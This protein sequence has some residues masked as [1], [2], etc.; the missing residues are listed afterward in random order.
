[1]RKSSVAVIL[2]AV[3]ISLVLFIGSGNS[4]RADGKSGESLF[5][6]HC[7]LCH[8]DGGNIVNPKKTLHKKDL[9]ANNIKSKDDI[10]H[11]MRKPGPG[12][13]TFDENTV[14]EKSAKEIAGYILKTFK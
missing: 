5:K 14:P 11:I 12:M 6:E 9:E 7:S 3:A 2:H 4:A 13:T 1:M 10:V 8:P